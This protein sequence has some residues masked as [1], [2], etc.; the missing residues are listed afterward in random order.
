MGEVENPQQQAER[1][2][3]VW[4]PSLARVICSRT[5]CY[6]FVPEK[7]FQSLP[8]YRRVNLKLP[9]CSAA[10]PILTGVSVLSS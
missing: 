1:K 10:E 3:F 4:C 5:S 8:A 6:C 7:V 9:V 2:G